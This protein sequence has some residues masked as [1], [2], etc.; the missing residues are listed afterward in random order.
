MKAKLMTSP[1]TQAAW[2]TDCVDPKKRCRATYLSCLPSYK[3]RTI[4]S[5]RSGKLF[6]LR[7]RLAGGGTSFVPPTDYHCTACDEHLGD[8]KKACIHCMV[9]CPAMW[10]ELDRFFAS[11][12]NLGGRGV[13]YALHLESLLG[14]DL[15]KAMI[16]PEED[17]LPDEL[18]G[19]Y[20]SALADLLSCNV[21]VDSGQ[22][23]GQEGSSGQAS[24][25][26]F[27]GLVGGDMDGCENARAV[28]GV[29]N[30]REDAVVV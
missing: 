21:S 2:F 20:W 1:T 9:D 6:S 28:L 8:S 16:N 19:G 17:F 23:L 10:P 5:A 24:T 11:V 30:V 27:L 18:T 29:A 26:A 15:V 12:Q 13:S 22:D 14:E 4:L 3:S 7:M 25:G